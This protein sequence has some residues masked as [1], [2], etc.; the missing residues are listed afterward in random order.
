MAENLDQAEISEKLRPILAYVTKLT[1]TPSK[2]VEADSQAVYEAG[3]KEDALYD[4][5]TVCALFNFMNR[6]VEGTGCLPK[7]ASNHRGNGKRLESYLEWGKD[8]G[9]IK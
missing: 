5:I 1:L 6:L 4:A 2:M 3:W 9:F 7:P 8:I